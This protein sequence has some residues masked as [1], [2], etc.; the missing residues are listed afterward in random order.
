MLPFFIYKNHSLNSHYWDIIIYLRQVVFKSRK[1][2]HY[3]YSKNAHECRSSKQNKC[4]EKNQFTSKTLLRIM[5]FNI[6]KQYQTKV[7]IM[8]TII[9]FFISFELCDSTNYTQN[10][11]FVRVHKYWL[12]TWNSNVS[13]IRTSN[14]FYFI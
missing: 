14:L 8:N 11:D 1:N 5:K 2:I 7:K 10:N 3:F 6:H 4:K 9:I 13:E 12:N